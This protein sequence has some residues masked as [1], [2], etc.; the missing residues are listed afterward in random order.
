MT[1]TLFATPD[2]AQEKRA[3]GTI[4][5]TSRLELGKPA[6]SIGD[7]LVHWAKTDPDRLFLAERGKDGRWVR[8]TY[9]QA[10]EKVRAAGA[11]MLANGLSQDHP[12]ALLSD[13]SIDHAVLALGAIYAGIPAAT[14]SQAYSLLS[15]DHERIK[16]MVGLLE[17]GAV[18]AS[19]TARFGPALKAIS[20]LHA[21]KVIT[22]DDDGSAGAVI[23]MA[24]VLA[25]RD[26]AAVEAAHAAITP[27]TIARLLF[28]SGSTG[29][30]KAVINTHRMLTANQEMRAACWP[31]LAAEPPVIVDWLPW[32]HT[33]GAN[34]NL[35]M[36]MRNGGTM[37]IDAGRPAPGAINATVANV[38][39]IGPNI[40]FN[41]PRGY[42]MMADALEADPEAAKRFF[43]AVKVIFYAAAA[44]PQTT[45]DKLEEL[46]QKAVGRKPALVSAWGSTETAP[47]A[48]DCHF[49]ATRSGN[50]GVPVPGV[51]LKLVPNAGKMEVRVRGPNVTPG[52]YRNEPQT[53]AAFDEEGFYLIG[54]AMKLAD[55]DDASKG[56]FF[57]GRVAEDFKLSTGTFVHVGQI[58]VAGIDA[59][60]PLAQDIVVTG[61]NRDAVG[62]LIFPNMPAARKIAGLGED[63]P[64][65]DVLA[66]P[67]VRAHAAKGLG[68]LKAEGG[69]SSRFATR[70]RLMA[71]P[72]SVDAGEINDKGYINQ[73]A[74][75]GNRAEELAALEGSDPQAFILPG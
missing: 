62:F 56:L 11:W 69:G 23:S 40:C 65:A 30:P 50:I 48:T 54:D 12:L 31:F 6:R 42:A 61:H 13:N 24:G 46:S 47:L 34:H 15:S 28:T 43:S 63:A 21:G 71:A 7:W 51:E 39:E 45:W 14:I 36:V 64:V 4:I 16:A 66:H 52:Y 17:P 1:N 37:Y 70:A 27:D 33:F 25:P 18:Y 58:R 10:L 57:D 67:A 22:S 8:L 9:G 41:V 72:P 49:Q 59:L 44:L 20:P 55:P 35:N 5:L 26:E 68:A 2:I 74:V 29:L 75:L 3:D 60:T 73:R 32:S 19:D 53:A 38:A